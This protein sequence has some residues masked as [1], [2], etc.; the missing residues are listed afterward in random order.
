MNIT[1]LPSG[2]YR[3]RYSENG[4][5]KA[6]TIDHKPTK[7]EA[8]K[9]IASK[10]TLSEFGH[11]FESA[12]K[13][14]IGDKRNILS[15]STIR[16]YEGL[17]KQISAHFKGTK[18]ENINLPMV[19]SEINDYA[20]KRSSKSVRNMS[21]F[22]MGV[23]RYY[24]SDIPSPKIPKKSNAL[25]YIPTKDEV[26]AIYKESKG[27]KYEVALLL[28]GMGLRRSEICA[29]TLS[30]LYGNTLTINK[31]LVQDYGEKWTI[32]DTKTTESERIITLPDYVSELIRK[33]GEIYSGYPSTI[34]VYL[35]KLQ[36]R[37]G[38]PRFSL[39]KMRHFF[40]SYMHE[41]GFSDKQIQDLGGWKT[42]NVMDTVY[43]HA[44]ETE[45]AR[46]T[47]ADCLGNLV[48]HS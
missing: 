43:K 36:D 34:N 9:L 45:K 21:G 41:Q 10:S 13:A 1:R 27:S 11:T 29:L 39:H 30:D 17:I 26:I 46:K 8:L 16:G 19:Q 35:H 23:L 25:P 15:P 24:G 37:L 4:K 2:N 48:T 47:A 22:I 40:A 18:I 5:R 28:A 38:I 42:S 7:A 3:I 44:L 12:C 6:F 20:L 33:N 32:K 14:Y 31:A